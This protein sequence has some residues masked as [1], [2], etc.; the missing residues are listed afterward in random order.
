MWINTIDYQMF[1]L[2]RFSNRALQRVY[3]LYCATEHA[4][5]LCCQTSVYTVLQLHQ[6]LWICLTFLDNS[7]SKESVA[8]HTSNNGLQPVKPADASR[9]ATGNGSYATVE[10]SPLMCGNQCLCG[11]E[12]ER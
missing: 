2:H 1:I 4:H 8:S 10:P 3:H 9:S 5:C 6:V 7:D 12:S 11:H